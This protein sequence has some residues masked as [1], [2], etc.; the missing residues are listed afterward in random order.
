[1]EMSDQCI[2]IPDGTI[3]NAQVEALNRA[4]DI[5]AWGDYNPQNIEPPNYTSS[6]D[7][8]VPVVQRWCEL[9]AQNTQL[10]NYILQYQSVAY[11]F[12]HKQPALALCIAFA[13]AAGLEWEK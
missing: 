13:Q 7:A 8:I 2:Q 12:A 11:F 4:I 9:S 1:M 3:V 5:H 10:L 6:L